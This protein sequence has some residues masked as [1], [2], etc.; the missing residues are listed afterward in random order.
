M[1]V[2][3]VERDYVR[4]LVMREE[5]QRAVTFS[6]GQTRKT[7]DVDRMERR[8]LEMCV[9]I[10]GRTASRV[11]PTFREAHPQVEWANF[12]D[13]S[14]HLLEQYNAVDLDWLWNTIQ[15][16]IPELI[17]ELEKLLPPEEADET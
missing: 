12:I 3:D 16:S 4:L 13:L 2:S 5:A 6:K 8:A 10:I 11:S 9:E 15:V 7:L 17:T 14:Q 1:A